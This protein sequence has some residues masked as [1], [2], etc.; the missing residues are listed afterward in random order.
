MIASMKALVA[1]TA[2]L[3]V[4]VVAGCTGSRVAARSVTAVTV[5]SV[6]ASLPPKQAVP[7]PPLEQLRSTMVPVASKAPAALAASSTA[8]WVQSHRSTVL[9]R[10]DLTTSRVTAEVRVDQLGCG[11]ITV[12]AGAV[13]QTGC[14]VSPGMVRVDEQ[15]QTVSGVPVNGLGAAILGG[16]VWIGADASG[17]TNQ[18]HRF[19]A[20]SL[21]EGVPVPVPG[22]SDGGGGTV[23]AAGAIWTTAT[24]G[25]VVHRID[26]AT[27]RVTAAIPLPTT[28]D[29]GYLVV[30][31]DAPLFTDP[32]SGILAPIDPL[33]DT[34]RIL[35]VR[36]DKPSS[37]W[38]VAAS[39]SPD[40]PG[41]V[42]VR[43]GDDEV[44]LVDTASDVVVRRLAVDAGR[45][46]DVQ[47]VG[48]VLWVSSFTHD[49]V[50]RIP[51]RPEG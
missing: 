47:Q 25:A 22:L 30:V 26:P 46:G 32:S 3:A 37:Y 49:A 28:A 42:W 23:A 41:H 40:R 43:S 2:L 44:W 36:T 24:H 50:E 13:W 8:L 7:L 19:N 35:A 10:I 1:A 27:G 9:S 14:G 17:A 5:P 45:G 38:G 4:G 51:L 48:D 33:T 11:D 31:D 20:T 21:A 15:T 12:G 29:Y 34:G 18:V 6:V 39:A 16:E